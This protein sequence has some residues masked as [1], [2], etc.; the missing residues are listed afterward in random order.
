MHS[1]N[2][3]SWGSTTLDADYALYEVFH[4]GEA[5]NFAFY[6]NGTVDQDLVK[7]RVSHNQQERQRLYADAEHRIM[8]DA[9]QLFLYY[10]PQT[11]A[12]R[13]GLENLLV[14]PFGHHIVRDAHWK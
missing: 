13:T 4:S 6:K 12:V 11:W 8:V 7:A 2:G 10:E 5:Y 9:P 1:T 3:L 14:L